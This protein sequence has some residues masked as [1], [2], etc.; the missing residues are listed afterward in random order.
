MN[1]DNSVGSDRKKGSGAKH[2]LASSLYIGPGGRTE[3][4]KAIINIAAH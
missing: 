1:F 3:S 2:V 4:L